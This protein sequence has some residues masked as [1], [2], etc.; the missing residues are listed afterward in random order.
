MKK[1]KKYDDF[2]GWNFKVGFKKSQ[3]NQEIKQNN[4]F[5]FI[6]IV[7]IKWKTF[8]KGNLFT[9]CLFNNCRIRTKKTKMRNKKNSFIHTLKS[10]CD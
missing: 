5:P 7:I 3:W 4:T 10:Y 9:L 6:Y 2:N 1:E 8:L